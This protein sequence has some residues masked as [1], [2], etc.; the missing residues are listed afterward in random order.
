MHQ[1]CTRGNADL[2]TGPVA[3]GSRQSGP[4]SGPPWHR[5]GPRPWRAQRHTPSCQALCPLGQRE[6]TAPG[7]SVPLR[8]SEESAG[9]PAAGAEVCFLT[10]SP[11]SGDFLLL[12]KQR[13]EELITSSFFWGWGVGV[14]RVSLSRS[15]RGRQEK[16]TQA[17][18]SN[19]GSTRTFPSARRSHEPPPPT[20]VHSICGPHNP[21]EGRGWGHQSL[22]GEKGPPPV[23]MPRRRRGRGCQVPVFITEP[24]PHSVRPR[25]S[26]W[27]M[28]SLLYRV[29]DKVSFPRRRELEG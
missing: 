1:Q 21:R 16:E 15:A 29:D 9:L 19:H 24:S 5:L 26:P 4:F 17:G 27:K 13:K 11:S 20:D 23:W 28:L 10:E 22:W 8:E 25:R 18:L 6:G 2:R 3:A 14:G 12:T 7:M